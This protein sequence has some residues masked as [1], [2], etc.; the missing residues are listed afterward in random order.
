L[1]KLAQVRTPGNITHNTNSRFSIAA[2]HPHYLQSLSF[3]KAELL[4]CCYLFI[5]FQLTLVLKGKSSNS[6]KQKRASFTTIANIMRC[7][8]NALASYPPLHMT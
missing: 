6:I 2:Y 4:F 3:K 5:T 8:F 1:I 7:G